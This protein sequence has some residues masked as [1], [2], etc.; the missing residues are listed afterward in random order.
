MT[1]QAEGVKKVPKRAVFLLTVQIVFA[2]ILF[3]RMFYLQV[4]ESDRYKM[5]ADKNR[6]SVRLLQPPRGLLIGTDGVPLAF[7]RK[8]FRAVLVAEDTG[9]NVQKTLANFQKLV[10][11]SQEEYD[12]ILKE[13]QKK[14]AFVPVQIKDDLSFDEMAAIQL[15]LPDLAGVSIEDSLVRVYPQ[16]QI[17]AHTLGYVS[18]I[19]EKDLNDFAQLQKMPDIRIGRTG[20][21]QFYESKLY[22][23]TGAR[24]M[25]IN[26]VGREVRELSK[27]KSVA[28]D[29]INLTLDSRLQE[30]AFQAMGEQTGAAVLMDIHTGAV[31][32]MV[33]TPAFDSNIF[34]EAIDAATWKD[35][36]TNEHHP[37]L[38]KAI[39][40]QYSP[41]SIFKIV[42][43]LAALESGVI[44]E[45]TRVYCDGQLVVGNHPFHCWRPHGHGSMTL[46]DALKN[47]C[48]VYFYQVAYDTGVDKI[49]EMAER[50]GLGEKTGID[51]MDEKVGFVPSRSWKEAR[52]GDAWRP[53]DTMNLGIGQGFLLVTPMQMVT[54][55]A[56]VANGGK[57]VVPHLVQ[58]NDIS[59]FEDLRI[60]PNHLKIVLKGLDAVVN[61][62]GG[63][64]AH[65]HINVDGD[66]MG[67]KTASTQIRRI[68]LKEREEGL[69]KQNEL[70][71][72]DRDHAFFV[73]YAPV[74]NPRYALV[75]AVEHGGG[76][77]SVA[78]PIAAKIMRKALQLDKLDKEKEAQDESVP[79]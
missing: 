54:L 68:T 55:M 9:G 2:F 32:T 64:A 46:K 66:K 75:V 25:E 60:N 11:L 79:R 6:I 23:K 24:K 37:L 58:Q 28:G 4:I 26:A 10:P 51:L 57:K 61:E 38:N 14:K 20:I 67:G 56:R 62:K 16:K 47:S 13:V 15:N 73:S 69:K 19:T 78:A 41:G 29:N 3:G 34:N 1:W 72:R 49:V 39:S 5:L 48:D 31:K 76:G 7:N 36:N 35:L 43:A 52:F 40:A 44:T 18:F 63:T 65:T 74:D 77:G 33:S 50:L 30:A 17:G 21:E 22:G 70:A 27:E 71:W 59:E 53:G 42:V 8:T 45:K 12:R